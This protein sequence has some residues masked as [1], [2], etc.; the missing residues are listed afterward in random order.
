MSWMMVIIIVAFFICFTVCLCTYLEYKNEQKKRLME[1][2]R[3]YRTMKM[4]LIQEKPEILKHLN[5][6]EM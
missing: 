1:S 3:E 6:N 4:K 5:I 2:E